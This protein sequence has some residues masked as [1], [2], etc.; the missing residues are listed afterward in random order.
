MILDEEIIR[1]LAYGTVDNEAGS[2]AKLQQ[3]ADFFKTSRWPNEYA[4]TTHSLHPGDARDLSW[5][6]DKS[7]HLV[8]T[9]PLTGR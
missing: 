2:V 8:V 5:I 7:V 3:V 9:S 6:P 1:A 4:N